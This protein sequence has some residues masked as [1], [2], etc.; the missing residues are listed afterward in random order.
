MENLKKHFDES[1]QT[2]T[3]AIGVLSIVTV[4]L[5]L[6]ALFFYVLERPSVSETILQSQQLKNGPFFVMDQNGN[7]VTCESISPRIGYVLCYTVHGVE[8]INTEQNNIVRGPV[9][10]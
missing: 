2:A 7:E 5:A 1:I 3:D 10:E 6:V 8:K 9:H 4:F